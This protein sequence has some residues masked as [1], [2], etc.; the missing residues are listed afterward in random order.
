M[1]DILLQYGAETSHPGNSTAEV[2]SCISVLSSNTR[3]NDHGYLS[4]RLGLVVFVCRPDRD[5]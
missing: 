2:E 1:S 4:F 3:Q 5:H